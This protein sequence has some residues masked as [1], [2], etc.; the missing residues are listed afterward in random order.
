MQNKP[1]LTYANIVSTL[2]LFLAL[3]TMLSGEV[4]N[5]ATAASTTGLLDARTGRI[6]AG[7]AQ[8]QVGGVQRDEGPGDAQN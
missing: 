8:R 3:G 1:R 4:A 5:E 2:A 7:P 6:G